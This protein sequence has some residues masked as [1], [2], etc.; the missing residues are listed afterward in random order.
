V[1]IKKD[2]LFVSSSAPSVLP[3]FSYQDDYRLNRMTCQ[4]EKTPTPSK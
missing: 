1:S 4:L 2:E 3:V